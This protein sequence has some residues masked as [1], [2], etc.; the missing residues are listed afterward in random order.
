MTDITLGIRLKADGS[1]LVGEVK[2][3]RQEL[4]KLG[5]SG[6]NAARGADQFNNSAKNMTASLS[7]MRGL[8][9]GIT[10]GVMVNFW[11]QSLDVMDNLDDTAVRL[12]FNVRA[13]QEY[14]Y[15][16]GLAGV[17]QQQ[18]E[19]GLTQ[20]SRTAFDAANG[21]E[22]AQKTFSRL[23]VQLFDGKG[24]LRSTEALLVDIADA[25]AK[26]PDPAE[27]VAI[28]MELFGRS[29]ARFAG[30]L[31]Q[32]SAELQKLRDQANAMGFVLDES[33]IKR[34]AQT[35]DQFETMSKIIRAQLMTA[36]LDLTPIIMGI[37]NGLVVAT[38][39]A[40]AF[41]D[42]FREIQNR[43]QLEPL[44]AEMNKLLDERAKVS[45]RMNKGGV[46]WLFQHSG[47]QAYVDTLTRRIND[48]NGRMLE[49]Q[50][51]QASPATGGGTAPP[52]TPAP[53]EATQKRL[54]AIQQIVTASELEAAK[55]GMTNSQLAAYQLAQLDAGDTERARVAAALDF[56]TAQEAAAAAD[57]AA[58]E[59][60][61]QI[62]K[63]ATER[64]QKMREESLRVFEETRTPQ[65]KFNER[66][67]DLNRLLQERDRFGAG[68]GVDDETYSRSALQAV[69]ALQQADQAQQSWL[70][71]QPTLAEQF[72]TLWQSTFDNFASGVGR[73][74]AHSLLYAQN[75]AGGMRNLL[76]GVAEQVLAT[77]I[78]I[79]VKKAGLWALEKAGIVST[80]A[81]ST[82]AAVTTAVA[83]APAAAAVSLATMGGNA[84]LAAT[85]ISS[86]F[87]LSQGL[88]LTGMAHD[89]L[90]FVPREGTYLL[91][92]GERVVKKEDNQLLTRALR[93]NSLGG[94]G[95]RGGVV[96]QQNFTFRA[97]DAAGIDQ[98][99]RRYMPA[100]RAAAVGAVQEAY[101]ARGKRGPLG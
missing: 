14:Q 86:T 42:Q 47:D 75:L 39:K 9:A 55:I 69:D 84:P 3:S 99:I 53:D 43:T 19:I 79:G 63:E 66:M 89:G 88:A 59:Q 41:I 11:R 72:N 70:T 2:L 58:A 37:A 22:S 100:I 26:I 21:V 10:G 18:F 38:S 6:K 24:H 30:A 82:A 36:M 8:L 94:A 60:G 57:K 45:E 73:T 12:G 31:Q 52:F 83:W 35:N 97:A 68:F 76:G 23:N 48:I 65:E 25:I 61:A 50:R 5:E 13:L 81:I 95:G 85:G 96:V 4:D 29:G 1:G 46:F 17:S 16:F 7:S 74:A 51:L 77:L 34:A 98:V 33:V 90:D 44:R 15:A 67:T 101:N 20:L 80:T 49:L 87:A 32:G 93:D 62:A 56:V 91:D 40:G 71:K 54:S 64:L 27:R 92:E 28:S 78:E